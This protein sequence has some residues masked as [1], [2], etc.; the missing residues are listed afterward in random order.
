MLCLFLILFSTLSLAIA[1]RSGYNLYPNFTSYPG[2][3]QVLTD[4][5]LFSQ[6]VTIGHYVQLA[7][8]G[9]WDTSGNVPSNFTA[10]VENAFKN[11]DAALQVAGSK[12]L[13]DIISVRSYVVGNI[14]AGASTIGE[15]RG[16]LLP[17]ILP[18]STT[19]GVTGLALPGQLVEIEAIAWVQ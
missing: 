15:V 16:A 6:A 5:R 8:Q 9:G 17:G 2:F 11:I 7:G 19:V 12:G 4:T 3:G 13:T 10:Q 14:S 1:S 18:T